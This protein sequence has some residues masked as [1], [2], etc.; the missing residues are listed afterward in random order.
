MTDTDVKPA[1]TRPLTLWTILM[2]VALVGLMGFL[3]IDNYRNASGLQATL[4]ERIRQGAMSRSHAIGYFF[5]DKR[6]DLEN[7]ARSRELSVYFDQKALGTSCRYGLKPALRR[8]QLSFSKLMERKIVGGEA[9][10]RRLALITPEGGALVDTDSHLVYCEPENF[11]FKSCLHPTANASKVRTVGQGGDIVVSTPYHYKGDYAGQIVAWLDSSVLTSALLRGGGSLESRG[12]VLVERMNSGWQLSVRETSPTWREVLTRLSDLMSQG[13]H[14]YTPEPLRMQLQESGEALFVTAVPVFGT[15]L[16]LVE[17]H[18]VD[19]V[20]RG[21][22]PWIQALAMAV[23]AALV[24][25]GVTV[26]FRANLGAA[27]LRARLV[28]AGLREREIAA[29]NEALNREVAERRR[30]EQ[31]LSVSE[32]QFRAIANYT[33]DWEDWTGPDGKL[34]WVNPAVERVSGYDVQTCMSMPDY[35]LPMVHP[36]DRDAFRSH[37]GKLLKHEDGELEFRLLHRD[38]RASWAVLTGQ[39]IADADGADMGLRCSV[40][41]ITERRRAAE[42]MRDAKE[43]AEAASQAKSDFLA[44]MS[45]EIR[46]PMVGVI[47]MTGLLRDS[48]LDDVQRDYV[49]TIHKSGEALLDVIN[50]IL[51]FSKIEAKRMELELT[52]FDLRATLEEVADILALRAFEKGL[53]FNCLLP[54][55]MPVRL[56]GDAGRLRQVLVNLTGNA[57]K[58]TDHGEVSVDVKRLDAE[59]SPDHCLLRFEVA[60]TGIGIAPDRQTQLFQSFYQVDAAPTRRHGGTGLGLAISKELVELMG[61]RIGCDSRPGAGSLFWFEIPFLLDP[62]APQAEPVP[63]DVLREK[64]VLVVDDNQTNLRVLFEYI[65]A[66]GCI[67]D[68]ADGA[69]PA[70]QRLEA[71]LADQR[72]YDIVVLDMMM[73]EVDGLTLGR[74]IRRGGQFGHPKLVMLSSRDQRSDGRALEEAGFDAYMM[75]PV[76]RNVLQRL[77]SRLFESEGE[78]KPATRTQGSHAAGDDRPCLRILVAEDNPTNQKVALSMLRKLGHRADAVSN[79]REAL[80]ALQLVPYDVVLMDVQ[81]PEMDGLEATRR[82]RTLES[83]TSRRLPIIA[84]TAHASTTDRDRCIDAGMDGFVTKPV[85]REVLGETIQEE[86]AR[87]AGSPRESS[88]EAENPAAADVPR[89]PINPEADPMSTAIDASPGDASSRAGTLASGAGQTGGESQM[90]TIEFEPATLAPAPD[91]GVQDA[92]E[93][94]TVEIMIQR[95]DN[96]EEIAREIAGIFVESSRELFAE[97]SRA[98]TDGDTDLVRARA[99]S[100]KGSAGNIGATTVQRLAAE[101]EQAGKHGDAATAKHLLPRL[102]AGLEQVFAVLEAWDAA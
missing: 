66:F 51:D 58:F 8:I 1:R 84:M 17:L 91:D 45:H 15:P 14:L 56:R 16:S 29:K 30:A 25:A 82:F 86:V 40:R 71:A 61:G 85:Q 63:D 9:I 53:Q 2:A 70:K 46:T 94:F 100:I 81:M 48:D 73:P 11:D 28:E 72:P 67:I 93:R 76:K 90:P 44:N 20:E 57:I 38:G 36:Q 10:Y 19:S 60:D 49:E 43:A 52:G 74:E 96:D 34:L 6:G 26:V 24:L 18:G 4:L 32:R 95:L 79:G 102:D 77:L 65:N 23:L 41:D 37:L 39:P 54:E 27:A 69:G 89:T 68:Q 78:A 13:S 33:Y 101:M 5:D 31:A 88:V 22:K 21:L 87:V 64:R 12:T 47:G 7:L 83:G 97:L 99:H 62:D 92:A 59:E 75:K 98:V 50:D 35:P 42:A 55:G 3:L 80:K